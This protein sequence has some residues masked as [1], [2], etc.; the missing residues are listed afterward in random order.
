MSSDK[1]LP[2]EPGVAS[3]RLLENERALLRR[4]KL[5]KWIFRYEHFVIIGGFGGFTASIWSLIWMIGYHMHHS[6]E[7]EDSIKVCI[8]LLLSI[9][10]ALGTGLISSSA[11][12]HYKAT[13]Q[14]L[15]NLP[16]ALSVGLK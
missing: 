6:T 7:F 10:M 12:I 9:T 2:E 8:I 5:L 16:G 3:S 13:N 14:Q 15:P 4:L 1:A 11:V